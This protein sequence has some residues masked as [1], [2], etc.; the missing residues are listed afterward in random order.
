MYV[1]AMAR[2]LRI[3]VVVLRDSTAIVPI[4]VSELLRKAEEL[5]A[6]MPLPPIRHSL[7]I[8]LTGATHTVITAGGFPVRCG[9]TFDE[10]RRSDLVVVPAL[11]PDITARLASNAKA[12]AWVRRMFK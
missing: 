2:P 8:T 9:A 3:H 4:A 1:R 6:S 5:A 10:V 11:D 12:V 7:S